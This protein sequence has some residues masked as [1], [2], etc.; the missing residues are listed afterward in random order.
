MVA[1]W[2]NILLSREKQ[3]IHHS[4]GLSANSIRQKTD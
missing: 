4:A 3:G 2:S 1:L